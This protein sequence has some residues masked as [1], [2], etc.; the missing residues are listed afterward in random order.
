[1]GFCWDSKKNSLE[2]NMDYNISCVF[3]LGFYRGLQ[4][5][6]LGFYWDYRWPQTKRS[7][8]SRGILEGF[9]KSTMNFLR[10]SKIFWLGFYRILWD[11]VFF[12]VIS[13]ALPITYESFIKIKG[14]KTHHFTHAL[15]HFTSL[16]SLFFT[17]DFG[18]SYPRP[19]LPTIN[20][21]RFYV[22]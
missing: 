8:D 18:E 12:L 2:I 4:K 22:T 19:S 15:T 7:W 16:T 6:K 21:A 11:S 1:M 9:Q 13:A 14:P 10:D 3:L 5:K 17:I 20:S